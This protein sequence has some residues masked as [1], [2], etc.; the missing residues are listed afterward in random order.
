MHWNPAKPAADSSRPSWR[1]GDFGIARSRGG[2]RGPLGNIGRRHRQQI[3]AVI[4]AGQER[5]L[6]VFRRGN[7]DHV[8]PIHIRQLKLLEHEVEERAYADFLK[9]LRYWR[10]LRNARLFELLFGNVKLNVRL[11]GEFV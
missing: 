6:G 3:A 10:V 7:D 1:T 5:A 2:N 4:D 9:A 11:L 8:V